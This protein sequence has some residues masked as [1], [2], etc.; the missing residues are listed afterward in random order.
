MQSISKL[1]NKYRNC[2]EEKKINIHIQK[3]RINGILSEIQSTGLLRWKPTLI[4]YSDRISL[5][6]EHLIYTLIC[7]TGESKIIGYKNQMWSYIC[8]DPNTAY[9]YLLKYIE[10]YVKGSQKPLFLIKSGAAWLDQ[11]Y[12]IKN[13]VIKQDNN[14]IRK[15]YKK[16]LETWMG[17]NYFK[18]EK[19][20]YI[21]EVL[22]KH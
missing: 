19:K 9:D 13:N 11:I 16:L 2:T 22:L 21:L 5:W 15:G 7:G 20:I 10:G 1:V 12:D 4:N 17:N 18:G 8:L 6:I 14:S 3:Y